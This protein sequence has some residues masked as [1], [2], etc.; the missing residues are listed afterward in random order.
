MTCPDFPSLRDSGTDGS[1]SRISLASICPPLGIS[2]VTRRTVRWNTDRSNGPRVLVP[3]K[4]GCARARATLERLH[5]TPADFAGHAE[6]RQ[7][8]KA[9]QRSAHSS[10]LSR[11]A[12]RP[13]FRSQPLCHYGDR[14]GRPLVNPAMRRRPFAQSRRNLARKLP[15]QSPLRHSAERPAC[16][17]RWI[18]RSLHRRESTRKADN[19][20]ASGSAR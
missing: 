14:M 12:R 9:H 2:T 3:P 1:L 4:L 7:R 18:Y 8:L 10:T 20:Y 5:L 11:P 6:H 15:M 17:D 13:A 16:D 19:Y